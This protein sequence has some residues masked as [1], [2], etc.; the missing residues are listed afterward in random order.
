MGFTKKTP[1]AAPKP[2]PKG[3]AIQQKPFGMQQPKKEEPKKD[4]GC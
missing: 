1:Q 3:P 4:S 2:S